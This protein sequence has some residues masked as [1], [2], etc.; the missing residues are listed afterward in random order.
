MKKVIQLIL[1]ATTF[2]FAFTNVSFASKKPFKGI[3]TYKI[4]FPNSEFDQATLAM[5]PK[6]MTVTIKGNMSKTSLNMG[7]GTQSTIFNG[8]NKTATTLINMMGQ[9]YAIQITREDIDKE[10]ADQPKPIV[11]YLDETKEI[12]GYKC[13]KAEIIFKNDD[14]NEVTFTVY[15]TDELGGK[16][17]NSGQALY[18]EI[19][20][21]LLEYEI[22]AKGMAM[23]FEATSVEKKNVSDKEFDIPE[24]YKITT[25]DELESMFGG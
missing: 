2:V 4:T 25:K 23:K 7:M 18:S 16:A 20:G 21:V 10:I 24:D 13:K 15:Y 17:L 12:A 8:D 14:D 5:M 1:I 22:D 3:I 6:V 11:K 19:D 9:K